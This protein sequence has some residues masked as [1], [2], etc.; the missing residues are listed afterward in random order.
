MSVLRAFRVVVLFCAAQLVPPVAVA[1]DE[2][3]SMDEIERMVRESEYHMSWQDQTVLSDLD[4]AW[5]ATNRA[6]NLRFYFTE[7]GLRVVDRTAEGSPEMLRLGVAGYVGS[8][9]QPVIFG[10][11]ENRLEISRG[12]LT[13]SFVNDE[14]GLWHILTIN[15]PPSGDG[16]VLIE[17]E[18]SAAGMS[19]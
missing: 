12:E 16:P 1:G 3:S 8:G 19:L 9:A 10:A 4:A 2:P 14:G 6:Q 17:L 15:D 11:S 7:D 13:E 18:W 5:H